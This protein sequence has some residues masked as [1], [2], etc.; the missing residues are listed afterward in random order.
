[1]I[2]WRT[3]SD[4]SLIAYFLTDHPLYFQKIGMVNMNKALVNRIDYWNNITWLINA[5]LDIM[6]DV[7]DLFHIQKEI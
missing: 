3:L 5:L 7:V 1:M 4:I 2:F 6:C